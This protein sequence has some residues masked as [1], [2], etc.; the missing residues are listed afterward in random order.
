[1]NATGAP[2]EDWMRPPNPFAMSVSL[3]AKR[4]VPAQSFMST[5]DV[6]CSRLPSGRVKV[7]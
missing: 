4:R 6:A 1:M 3:S 7:M 5:I 2:G